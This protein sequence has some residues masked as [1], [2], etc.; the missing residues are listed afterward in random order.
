VVISPKGLNRF[1]DKSPQIDD[2]LSMATPK[3]KQSSTK[4]ERIKRMSREPV[5]KFLEPGEGYYKVKVKK[6][7]VS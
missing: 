1:G 2:L 4:L 5:N 3:F 6:P 7:I